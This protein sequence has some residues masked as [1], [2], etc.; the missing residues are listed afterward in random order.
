MATDLAGNQI[1]G[2]ER[3]KALEKI[4]LKIKACQPTK[5]R[6]QSTNERNFVH[7]SIIMSTDEIPEHI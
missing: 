3:R 1:P 7:I 6:L 2:D 5:I 4:L